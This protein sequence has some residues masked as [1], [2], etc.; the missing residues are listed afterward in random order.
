LCNGAQARYVV[1]KYLQPTQACES[2]R[3]TVTII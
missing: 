2:N 3:K 1:D